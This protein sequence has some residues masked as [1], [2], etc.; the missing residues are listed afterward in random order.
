MLFLSNMET[1]KDKRGQ[2]KTGPDRTT[3]EKKKPKKT[4]E[5]RKSDDNIVDILIV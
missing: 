3:Q 2:S 5:M 1:V 4:K